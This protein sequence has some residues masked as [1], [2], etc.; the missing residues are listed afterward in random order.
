MGLLSAGESDASHHKGEH[1]PEHRFRRRPLK[2]LETGYLAPDAPIG[3][4]EPLIPLS[5]ASFF[6]RLVWSSA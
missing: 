5:E 4:K 6:F 3:K 1:R 2:P